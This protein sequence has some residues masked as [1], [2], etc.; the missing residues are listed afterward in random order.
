MRGRLID[1]TVET[2]N[3]DTTRLRST[4][5]RTILEPQGPRAF[6]LKHVLP[7]EPEEESNRV[8]DMDLGNLLHD[9]VLRGR[10][11]WLKS[12]L[13]KNSN[14]FKELAAANRGKLFLSDKQERELLRWHDAIMRNKEA[15]RIVE[16]GYPEVT[17][18]MEIDVTLASGVVETIDC[19]CRFDIFCSGTGQDWD[20]KTTCKVDRQGFERQAD[21]LGYHIQAGFYD[22]HKEAIG[23]FDSPHSYIVVTKTQPSYCYVWPISH[24]VRNIGRTMALE[25]LLRLAKCRVAQRE[26]LARNPEADP[27][28]A[29]PDFQELNQDDAI[30][31]SLNA[32]SR[33]GWVD[34]EERGY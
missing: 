15:K 22:L 18:H 11:G 30:M 19:K 3:A 25:A 6:Y 5:L 8:T 32:S 31:P 10:V 1:W 9:L 27:I 28:E 2:Y 17:G 20:I 7:Q 26:W 29:W 14:A 34:A 23:V 21:D 24:Q 12:D 4:Q 16:L 13:S 33:V